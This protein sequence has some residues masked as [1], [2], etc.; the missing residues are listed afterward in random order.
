MKNL[1]PILTFLFCTPGFAA[2]NNHEETM[3]KWVDKNFTGVLPTS[4]VG[5]AQDSSKC[6]LTYSQTDGPFIS[7][8]VI[9]NKLRVND[10]I[11]AQLTPDDLV[12]SNSTK[13]V[14][15]FQSSPLSEEAKSN[16]VIV[17]L[18][19]GKPIRATGIS[20]QMTFTCNLN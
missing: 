5:T 7:A 14:F 3:A 8:M 4:Y 13:S 16:T 2:S 11:M 9:K 19:D 10:V 1:I 17:E 20:D 12:T 6:S 15:V 18:K